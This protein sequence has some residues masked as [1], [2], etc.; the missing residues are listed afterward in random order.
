MSNAPTL[1]NIAEVNSA[2]NFAFDFQKT[3]TTE[4]GKLCA[5]FKNVENGDGCKLPESFSWLDKV[6]IAADQIDDLGDHVRGVEEA[7]TALDM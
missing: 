4:D 3:A 2:N 1:T 7:K 5:V 6:Y